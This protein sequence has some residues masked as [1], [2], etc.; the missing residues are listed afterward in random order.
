MMEEAKKALDRLQITVNADRRGDALS[1]GQ[2]QAVAIARAL[3]FSPKI[4]LMDEPTSA[5]SVAKANLVIE[6]TRKLASEGLGI[7]F[8]TPNPSHAYR[9]ADRIYLIHLGKIYGEITKEK[10]HI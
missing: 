1:G 3:H 8:V 6:M 9:V 7:L 10:N 2:R 4:L 5:L